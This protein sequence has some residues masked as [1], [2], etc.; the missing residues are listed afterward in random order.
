MPQGQGAWTPRLLVCLRW[1]SSKSK[2][3]YKNAAM[4]ANWWELCNK[5][6]DD[7]WG[8]RYSVVMK[9]VGRSPGPDHMLLQTVKEL[10]RILPVDTLRVLNSLLREQSSLVPGKEL[11]LPW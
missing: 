3:S 11:P 10:V 7:V 1:V 5:L 8:D 2:G 6:D 9:H 4:K